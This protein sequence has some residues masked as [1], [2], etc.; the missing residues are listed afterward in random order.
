MRNRRY[1]FNPSDLKSCN[2]KRADCCF[3][4]LT[5][6][7]DKY[8]YSL[9][10]VLHC[11]LSCGFCCH[12]SCERSGLTGTSVT[13]FARGSPRNCVSVGIGNSYYSVIEAGADMSS[14]AFNIF[15]LAA[16]L[17]N[18]FSLLLSQFT[19]CP[20]ITSSFLRWSLRDLFWFSRWSWF[21]DLLRGDPF[22]DADRDS[23]RSRPF[24]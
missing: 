20:P 10:T 4:A 7:L 9:K 19:V 24:S 12:L 2:L 13:E 6:T 23:S 18:N 17:G 5:G 1:I 16:L 15:A 11:C 8:F 14:T 3:S 22:C 21:S